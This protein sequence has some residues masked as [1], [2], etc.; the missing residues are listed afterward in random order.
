MS[1]ALNSPENTSPENTS[2]EFTT[3]CVGF[4]EPLRSMCVHDQMVGYDHILHDIVVEIGRVLADPL[5]HT[6]HINKITV[7]KTENG[8][9]AITLYDLS[10]HEMAV[11]TISPV[12][13]VDYPAPNMEITLYANIHPLNQFVSELLATF[14]WLNSYQVKSVSMQAWL[15][16]MTILLDIVTQQST[17][18]CYYKVIE[19]FKSEH[20]SIVSEVLNGF[21][22]DSVDSFYP[23][24]LWYKSEE[25]HNV[26]AFYYSMI[27]AMLSAVAMLFHPSIPA[28]K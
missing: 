4:R 27:V 21:T 10:D 20:M 28:A 25:P 14:E 5:N 22:R 2:P 11:S 1:I 18:H 7:V 15:I 17:D 26:K 9:I 13:S 16:G 24:F 3:T 19:A 8:S 12:F 23:P 6:T